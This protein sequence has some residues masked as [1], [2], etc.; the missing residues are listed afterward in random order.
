MVRVYT[1]NQQAPRFVGL[2]VETVVPGEFTLTPE[3]GLADG[4]Y[5]FYAVASDKAGNNSSW[6]A[7]S[8]QIVI[9]TLAPLEPTLQSLIT[10]TL[11][12]EITGWVTLAA[13]ES[14]V[15]I[16]DNVPYPG[17]EGNGMTLSTNAGVTTW[18]LQ[19]PD[20]GMNQIY[21]VAVTVTDLAGNS[22]IDQSS[23]E[24][25]IENVK[26]TIVQF[27]STTVDGAY[28]EGSVIQIA[29]TVSET[30]A[31]GAQIEV[32]LSTG[33]KVLLSAATQGKVLTGSYAVDAGENSNDLAI[34]SFTIGSGSN[35]PVDLAGNIMISTVVPNTLAANRAIVIDTL[36]PITPFVTVN[37]N[38]NPVQGPVILNGFT[39]DTTPTLN[40]QAESGSTVTVYES[41]FFVGNAQ[42]INNSG[43]FSFT[44][45][46]AQG[47]YRYTVQSADAAGNSVSSAEATFTV[48]TLTPIASTLVLMFQADL[49]GLS[50]S[51]ALGVNESLEVVIAGVTYSSADPQAG[52]V[53]Q[54]SQ[55]SL[56]WPA[57]LDNAGTRLVVA[58]VVDAAGNRSAAATLS[59]QTGSD[60][61]QTLNGVAGND[62]IRALGGNDTIN[63]NAGND[64]LDGGA[65]NDNI[66]GGA[67]NDTLSGGIG[68]DVINGGN[69]IDTVTYASATAGV[70]VNLATTAAQNTVAAGS[71]TLSNVENLLGSAFNDTLTGSNGANLI[72]GGAGNDI[73]TG[74]GGADTINGGEGS[75]LYMVNATAD[76]PVAELVSDS[77]LGVNDIDELRYTSNAAGT[78]T[79]A[80]TLVGIER[81]VVGTGTAAQALDTGN[82]AI[83]INAAAVN[84]G[85][86]II[87]NSG[88]NILTGTNLS[89]FLVGGAGNDTLIGNAG[90]DTL[91]GGVGNDNFVF[92]AADYQTFYDIITDFKVSGTDRLQLS[93]TI[94]TGL[95]SATPN[96]TGVALTPADL[97][98]NA[99]V[100]ASSSTGEHLLYDSD[101]GALYYD[102]D[103]Q[104]GSDAFQIALLGQ[105]SHPNLLSTDILVIV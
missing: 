21:D 17:V 23:S 83:N 36:A 54:G 101:S 35:A 24:L 3:T 79:L 41:G 72:S 57:V 50:G 63:G 87:G 58:S 8:E 19:L 16:V 100:T 25:V 86:T 105:V 28:K 37:D 77:G 93:K 2:A 52:F 30:I 61:A 45:T 27:E 81:V 6:S 56:P 32:T 74:A 75:D 10:N 42:E 98:S 33:A 88:A 90:I 96:A 47:S 34:E 38:T 76:F 80:A 91:T 59:V 67:G 65:G 15:V 51:T 9:D 7:A 44:P 14:F 43:V 53:W 66:Q 104:G 55:W 11:S 31:A 92:N 5:V 48:D 22:R 1:G 69:G 39:N 26:P 29:A 95:Q 82:A 18:K 62:Y 46:L 20:M 12:P 71:D 89:D 13:G 49:P 97:L 78:L 68:N 99:N 84:S 70:T 85:L 103:G 40:I 64:L 60:A 4:S 102:V 94:F 73:L